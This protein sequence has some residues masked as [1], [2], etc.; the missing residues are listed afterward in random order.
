MRVSIEGGAGAVGATARESGAGQMAA[1]DDRAAAV[2]PAARNHERNGLDREMRCAYRRST[3]AEDMMPA[4]ANQV[5]NSKPPTIRE[6][7]AANGWSR[8]VQEDLEKAR[9]LVARMT[10]DRFKDVELRDRKKRSQRLYDAQARRTARASTRT[11]QTSHRSNGRLRASRASRR[12]S[13]RPL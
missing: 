12:P 13:L 4:R 1:A 5:V 9:E 11:E 6:V 2:L 3:V 10:D 7:L 8:H